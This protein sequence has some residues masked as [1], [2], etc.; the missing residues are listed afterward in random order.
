MEESSEEAEISNFSFEASDESPRYMETST[1]PAPEVTSEQEWLPEYEGQLTVDVYQTKDDVIIQSVVAGVHAED[2][3]ITIA[4]DKVTIEGDRKRPV[5]VPTEDYFYQECYWGPFSR[6]IVL[7]VDV[8]MD[9]V[10]AKIRDG[11][12]TVVLPKAAK[13]KVKKVQVKKTAE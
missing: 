10:E 7:P 3:D 13:A 5:E 2:I 8:D 6:S 11:I 12:L 4:N 1:L 9:N